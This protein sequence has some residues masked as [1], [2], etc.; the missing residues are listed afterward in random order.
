M[1]NEQ[2]Q[3]AAEISRLATAVAYK[4]VN[5]DTAGLKEYEAVF[6]LVVNYVC[7]AAGLASRTSVDDATRAEVS[8][9]VESVFPLSGVAYFIS[10]PAVERLQQVSTIFS[11]N[12]SLPDTQ[13]ITCQ[14]FSSAYQYEYMQLGSSFT[15]IA[16]C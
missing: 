8:A 16:L 14:T 4:K 6:E 2:I 13:D 12:L 15:N 9:A 5:L 3:Q 7:A 1:E 10:L 11:G